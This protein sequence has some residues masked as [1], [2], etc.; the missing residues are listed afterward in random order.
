MPGM[1]TSKIEVSLVSNRG[2]WLLLGDEELFVLFADFPWFKQ[3]S[4]L[5]LMA[6]ERL[7]GDHLYWPLIDVDLALGSIRDPA[8]FPLVSKANAAPQPVG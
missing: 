8:A 4:I 3:A 2:F 7:F 1:S 6:I 5:Q